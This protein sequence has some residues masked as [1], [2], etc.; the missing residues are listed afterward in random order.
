MAKSE[1][2][3]Q[4]W[5]LK[6]ALFA[7]AQNIYLQFKSRGRLNEARHCFLSLGAQL[8]ADP[9]VQQQQLLLPLLRCSYLEIVHGR[10]NG[11]KRL[12]K[13]G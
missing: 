8:W 4:L 11:L 9:K 10:S 6:N 5:L 1:T 12:L 13:I 7:S 2:R 3:W